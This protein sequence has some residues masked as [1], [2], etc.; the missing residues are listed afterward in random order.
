MVHGPTSVPQSASTRTVPCLTDEIFLAEDRPS[1]LQLF[2]QMVQLKRQKEFRG[3]AE[4][5]AERA[6]VLNRQ[7]TF[8]A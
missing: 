3:N 1:G 8:S 6:D 7:F 4:V 2:R 5:I